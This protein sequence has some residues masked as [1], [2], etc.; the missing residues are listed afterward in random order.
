M[1][2][3]SRMMVLFINSFVA[4]CLASACF[5]AQCWLVGIRLEVELDWLQVLGGCDRGQDCCAHD[6][7]ESNAID[8]T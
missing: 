7:R 4:S 1:N 8:A 6:R 5:Q 3:V 2:I